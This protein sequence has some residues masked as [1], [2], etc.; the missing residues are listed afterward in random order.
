[1]ELA[2]RVLVGGKGAL[3]RA[4]LI[5]AETEI[6]LQLLHSPL[7]PR[8]RGARVGQGHGRGGER[9]RQSGEYGLGHEL[10]RFSF[11]QR[12]DGL[13]GEP[14]AGVK[15]LSPNRP[16][17]RTSRPIPSRRSPKSRSLAWCRERF[18]SRSGRLHRSG[19]T[20]PSASPGRP[21]G[22]RSPSNRRMMWTSE[23][24]FAGRVS[25]LRRSD[26]AEKSLDKPSPPARSVPSDAIEPLSNGPF[27]P[28][29]RRLVVGMPF[30]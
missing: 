11:R 18:R 8:S 13:D 3:N 24:P 30:E 27:G 7:L 12:L 22:T 26:A 28:V 21:S 1:M 29:L 17:R 23:A 6:R 16:N 25:T 14:I 10:H 2:T 5:V 4:R 15:R 19:S 20:S 9:Q